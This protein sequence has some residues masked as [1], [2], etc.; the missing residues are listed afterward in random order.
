[1]EKP[2][3]VT[4]FDVFYKTVQKRQEN[5]LLREGHEKEVTSGIEALGA[6]RKYDP[7]ECLLVSTEQHS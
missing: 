3:A 7:R 5:C 1:V 6:S 4:P 2:V